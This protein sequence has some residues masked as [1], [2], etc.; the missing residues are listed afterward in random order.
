V[1]VSERAEPDGGQRWLSGEIA[2][3][4][5]GAG[6]YVIELTASTAGGEQKILTAIRVTR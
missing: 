6:D 3:A 4:A 2:L 5:L 1:E